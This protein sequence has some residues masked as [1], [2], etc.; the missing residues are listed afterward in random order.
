MSKR[1]LILAALLAGAAAAALFVS[2]GTGGPEPQPVPVAQPAAPEPPPPPPPVAVE[3]AGGE[4]GLIAVAP[5]EKRTLPEEAVRRLVAHAE[6]TGTEALLV[7]HLGALQLEH[8]GQ[9]RRASDLLDGRGLQAGILSLLA[10]KAL[11]DGLIGALDEPLH[12]RFPEWAGDGRGRVT[13]RQLLV[14]TSG[15]EASGDPRADAAAW[16][17]SAKLAVEPGSRFAPS[18]LEAQLLSM[19]LAR[20]SGKSY[21]AYLSE[22]LW[23]PLGARPAELALDG[24]GKTALGW[25][26]FKAIARDWLRLGLLLKDGGA[27]AGR[28]VVPTPWVDN[29]QKPTLFARNQGLRVLIAWPYEKDGQVRASEP[30]VDP[31]TVFIAG[32]GGQRIYVSEAADL[33]ILRLGREVAGWD[34]SRL[35][36]MVARAIQRPKERPRIKPVGQ[37]VE[38][39]PITK[40]PKMPVV[41]TVPLDPPAPAPAGN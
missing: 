4:A 16:A 13:V 34:D 10:G 26:C 11:G 36:N 31:D 23:A 9:G 17:L 30:F 25:C 37:G 22:S 14:G 5:E 32:A 33:V 27:A 38:L 35:P 6:E 1:P 41:E 28:P 7:W 15:L 19:L 20:A 40:P 21:P 3:V 12:V 24:T 18:D 2:L 8:Y 29:I 39:P